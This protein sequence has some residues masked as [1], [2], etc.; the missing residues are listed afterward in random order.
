MLLPSTRDLVR[1][2]G[3][4]VT[5]DTILWHPEALEVSRARPGTKDTPVQSKVLGPI[6]DK[7]GIGPVTTIGKL[8]NV[9][10]LMPASPTGGGKYGKGHP[11]QADFV[12][13]REVEVLLTWLS[14]RTAGS[15]RFGSSDLDASDCVP[16]RAVADPLKHAPTEYR[17]ALLQA[18]QLIE[19]RAKSLDRVP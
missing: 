18:R 19:N 8:H 1:I 10:G 13:L 3:R 16:G 15:R 4:D 17:G 6:L 12:H 11:K 2:H 14:L 7:R 5:W 9:G